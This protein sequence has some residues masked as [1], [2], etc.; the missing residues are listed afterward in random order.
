MNNFKIFHIQKF[1]A[2]SGAKVNN[3]CLYTTQSS[4]GHGCNQMNSACLL[5]TQHT[6]ESCLDSLIPEFPV[7]C[8]YH[9][10]SNIQRI[11]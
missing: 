4:A 11:T 5:V 6:S 10:I 7:G 3:H 8:S 1:P 9:V 2:I